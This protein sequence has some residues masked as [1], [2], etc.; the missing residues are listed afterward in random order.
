MDAKN[1]TAVPVSHQQ[2]GWFIPSREVR[3]DHQPFS[4]G[5]FGKV[6]RG[7]WL[8][9]RVVVKTVTV[10]TE[11]ENRTFHREARIWQKAR[12]PNIVPFFGACDE[13]ST[14]FFVC[15]EAKNGK[16]LDYL[17]H[18]REEASEQDGDE[19]TV[20]AIRW[21][22]PEVIRKEKPV[23]P[24]AQSDVYSLGMCVV[25]A[26]TGDVP[27]GQHVPVPVVK[28]HV[29]R[30]KFLPRPNAFTNDKQWLL[31]EKL[32]AFEPSERIKLADA[33]EWIRVFAEEE[34]FQ[35]RVR[36]MKEESPEEIDLGIE[37]HPEVSKSAMGSMHVLEAEININATDEKGSSALLSAA[38]NGKVD[39]VRL[40]LEKGADY[41]KT[42]N[43]EDSPLIVAATEG[44]VE[45]VH[46]L[47]ESGDDI[48]KTSKMATHPSSVQ[49]ND[50]NS[51]LFNFYWKEIVE[52]LE[53]NG[54]KIDLPT[55]SGVTPLMYAAS[56]GH[57]D[58][59]QFLLEKGADIEKTD[60]EGYTAKDTQL[61]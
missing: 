2:P 25:E 60:N 41:N 40:L 31:V 50:V 54:A 14:F 52:I 29:T 26:V 38:R 15:E 37:E 24:N 61:L 30:K 13:G 22:A 6:Y 28:F 51:M 5:S 49:L 34:R 53:K 47:L 36:E 4:A 1:I 58:V 20:G 21:K 55:K 23:T 7:W 32:C 18:N 39:V 44:H 46:I 17:Y 19:E 11:K 48:E 42:D 33:I 59:V 10:A 3:K 16:L 12:H 35:E 43:K 9:T 27:W 8:N 57:L 45:I 56:D